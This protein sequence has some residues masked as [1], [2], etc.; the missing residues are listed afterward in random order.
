M[1]LFQ[2]NSSPQ[3]CSLQVLTQKDCQ[4]LLTTLSVF[5]SLGTVG[6]SSRYA[7]PD[8]LCSYV[9][10]HRVHIN[11]NSVS[12]FKVS[13]V[14]IFYYIKHSCRMLRPIKTLR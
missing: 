11:F 3:K 8:S 10:S 12:L 14:E 5:V 6:S 2:T 1:V 4:Q 7:K 9:S 13:Y